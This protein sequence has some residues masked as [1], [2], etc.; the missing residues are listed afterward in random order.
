MIFL[1][2]RTAVI[3]LSSLCIGPK[4]WKSLPHTFSRSLPVVL[5]AIPSGIVGI[6]YG[7]IWENGFSLYSKQNVGYQLCNLKN[8][9][10]V[11][12]SSSVYYAKKEFCG[13]HWCLDLPLASNCWLFGRTTCFRW[14]A[15]FTL[16]LCWDLGSLKIFIAVLYLIRQFLLAAYLITI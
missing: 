15:D 16:F 9:I 11:I 3:F 2:L 10:E 1:I 13:Y 8:K 12:L 6:I 5:P 4:N 14:V 7:C